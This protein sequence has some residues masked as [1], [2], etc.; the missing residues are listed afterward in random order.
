MKRVKLLAAVL[1]ALMTGALV[2]GPAA[3]TTAHTRRTTDTDFTSVRVHGHAGRQDGKVFRGRMDVKRFARDGGELVA[4]GRVTGTMKNASGRVIGE[5][6]NKKVRWPLASASTRAATTTSGAT[7]NAA[8]CEVLRLV[9][10]PL[11]LDLLGLQVHLNRVVLTIDAQSGP[12]NLLGN[13]V[14]AIANLL[15][16]NPLGDLSGNLLRALQNLLN[17]IIGILKL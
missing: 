15:N 17:A 9:L 14:C 6:E 12:G 1:A 16:G 13:L 2:I 10:G 5:V 8:T 11:D 4:V 3:L 7:A